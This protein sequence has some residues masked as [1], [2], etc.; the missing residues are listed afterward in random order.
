MYG[1]CHTKGAKMSYLVYEHISPNGKIYIGITCQKPNRR[2]Q[3]GHGY[4]QNT[5]FFSAIK[6]Y[7]WNNFQHIIVAENMTKDD[8]CKLEQE[9]IAKYKSSNPKFGYNRSTG[10]EVGFAGIIVSEETRKKIGDANRGEKHYLY[11]KHPSEEH[12]KRMSESKRGEKN[13]FYG[14]HFSKESKAKL[15]KSVI[16]I[17]TGKI[18][19]TITEA[20]LDTKIDK[21]DIVRACKGKKKT[22]GFLHWEYYTQKENCDAE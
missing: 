11:G 20:Q 17:E 7:G 1:F 16:C 12:R 21:S 2:W 9:L 14:K 15:G 6:K 22:A 8:A 4:R 5:H 13:P 18:Y 3:A 10:G 19:P